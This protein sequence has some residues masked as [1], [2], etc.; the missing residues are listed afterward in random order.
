[1]FLEKIDWDNPRFK[2]WNLKNL[3]RLNDAQQAAF[4]EDDASLPTHT[5]ASLL[6]ISRKKKKTNFCSHF[7]R[8]SISPISVNRS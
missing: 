8:I 2:K 4:F 5:F 1:M 6:L 3:G 7:H